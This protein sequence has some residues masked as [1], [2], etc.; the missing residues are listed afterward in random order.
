M[1]I[2]EPHEDSYLLQKY[3]KKYSKVN[4]VLDMGTGSGLQA[5]SASKNAENVLGV[6]IN[7]DAIKQAIIQSEIEKIKN[8][9]FI[10]SD[11]FKSVPKEKFDLIIFN[12]PYL[13]KEK[14]V[15]DI[16]LV[17]GKRGVDTTL[18]FLNN[19][20]TFLEDNGTIL[21]IT[22]S[23]ASASK[24]EECINKN[25]LK[26]KLLETK[27][28]FFEDINV[29]EIKKSN[30]LKKLEK[31]KVMNP[32]LFSH[33]KRGVI[34]K[35]KY[36]KK[37]VC[38]KIKK[39][40]S[41]AFGTI[42]NEAKFLKILNDY[43]IGPKLIMHDEDYLMYIFVEGIFIEDILKDYS[44]KN[45]ISVLTNVFEQMYKMDQLNINKF[46]MHHP[47]KHILIKNKGI[48]LIDFERARYTQDPKNV[49]QFCDFIISKKVS[50]YLLNKDF[51]IISQEIIDAAIIY[52]KTKNKSNFNKILSLLN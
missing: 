31:L 29:V 45:I 23:L 30:I 10:K 22:S 40:N 11:L 25:L 24:I 51:K 50:E 15:N 6:D 18:K 35:G 32:K 47:Y 5:F 52:K 3:V 38:I 46:E 21:L 42:R 2:Y 16:A 41:D 9:N 48:I 14:H 17:S 28:V 43:N 12:P 49:T 7:P 33:G 13:P 44:K 1:D 36:K 27:H 39:E 8:V 4:N 20:T 19:V 34:I 37:S 26:A